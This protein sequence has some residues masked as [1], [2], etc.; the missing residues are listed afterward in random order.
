MV[1]KNRMEKISGKS[2]LQ[3]A[4]NQFNFLEQLGFKLFR[5]EAIDDSGDIAWVSDKGVY[6]SVFC[7]PP[8]FDIGFHFGRIGIDEKPNGFP[9]E[10][11]DLLSLG[12]CQGWTWAANK[13]GVDGYLSEYAR[14]LKSCG[15][16]CLDGDAKT[17]DRM[18]AARVAMV[19]DWRNS[20]AENSVRKN[21]ESAWLEKRYIDTV[22]LY[23]NIPN[24]SE[25]EK[26]RLRIAKKIIENNVN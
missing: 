18:R 7:L 17:F 21:A 25:V 13:H 1:G 24:L 19:S 12:E 14:L 15:K 11:G 5:K 4:H 23:E 10:Q 26:S 2:F 16:K 20:M 9:F 8:S 22:R 6:V 3:K